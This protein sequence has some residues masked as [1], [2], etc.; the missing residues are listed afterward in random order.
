MGGA[1]VVFDYGGVIITPI[2]NQLGE[3][4]RSHGVDTMVM[5][6]LLMG[7]RHTSGDHPWHRAERGELPTD[8]MQDL[9]GPY[10]TDA[11]ID[12][13]GDE[14]ARLLNAPTYRYHAQVVRRIAGL[15]D[16]G[17]TTALLTN[18]F[19]EFRPVL[20]SQLDMGLFDVVVDS[21]AEGC[22]KP[23]PE[24]Y[25]IV[26][27]RVGVPVDRTIYL[28]DFDHNLGPARRLGWQVIHVSDPDE[29]LAEL[30]RQL[31]ALTGVGGD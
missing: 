9:I 30:D 28:D 11:G 17:V 27:E 6:E 20:E 29:A 13:V 24:I 8:A 22:R 16:E 23:E 19:R 4:A 14:Y 3:I 18:S 15:R 25:A 26:S 7:P 21:S 5:L 10:A 12:L 2:T 31:A 1:A